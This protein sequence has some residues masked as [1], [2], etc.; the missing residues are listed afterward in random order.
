VL[1][2]AGHARRVKVAYLMRMIK[3]TLVFPETI[4]EKA[5]QF[6][7]FHLEFN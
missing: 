7:V 6:S 4:G 3:G 1:S 5:A 2:Q